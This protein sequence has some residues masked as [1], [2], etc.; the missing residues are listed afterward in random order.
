MES[1]PAASLGL[2]HPQEIHLGRHSV[3]LRDGDRCS[4]STSVSEPRVTRSSNLWGE[5]RGCPDSSLPAHTQSTHPLSASVTLV[6][7]M[8]RRGQAG[9]SWAL[10]MMPVP[11]LAKTEAHQ[12]GH[13]CM[14]RTPRVYS[15]TMYICVPE[16]STQCPCAC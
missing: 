7:C 15:W 4:S 12:L 13:T 8:E 10:E 3:H 1:L 16:T 6:A 14:P 11:T 5:G 2:P 9:M